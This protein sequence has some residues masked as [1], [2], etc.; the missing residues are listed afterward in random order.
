MREAF[1]IALNL[2][3][4]LSLST[5]SLFMLCTRI[6]EV[7][8]IDEHENDNEPFFAI[9]YLCIEPSSGLHKYIH[10]NIKGIWTI[11]LAICYH[12]LRGH[13]P[14]ITHHDYNHESYYFV[15]IHF[16]HLISFPPWL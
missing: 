12:L 11:R 3:Q 4:S 1:S 15:S 8:D 16:Y 5:Y 6:N 13:Y 7:V 14:F 10:F 9:I 2:F